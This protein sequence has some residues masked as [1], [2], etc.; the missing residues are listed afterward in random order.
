MY[1]LASGSTLA[2]PNS[3]LLQSGLGALSASASSCSSQRT[4]FGFG[5]M[6]ARFPFTSSSAFGQ[7]RPYFFIIQAIIIVAL[8]DIPRAQCTSTFC[9][10]LKLFSIYSQVG[11][12]YFLMSSRIESWM[13]IAAWTICRGSV[14]YMFEPAVKTAPIFRFR[15]ACMSWAPRRLLRQSA[16]RLSVASIISWMS[17]A[18]GCKGS[19]FVPDI[20]YSDLG[21]YYY[22]VGDN[23]IRS[24]DDWQKN[25]ANI[26]SG[27]DVWAPHLLEILLLLKNKTV[28]MGVAGREGVAQT[29]DGGAV[30]IR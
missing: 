27:G 28:T 14:G 1:R 9:L 20:Q 4:K 29:R 30:R 5:Q 8:R 10:S 26:I 24:S 22:K 23:L 17:P 11:S 19:R 21:Y 15:R 3:A 18:E 7:L 2:S 16:P 13:L 6:L 25:S 12:K